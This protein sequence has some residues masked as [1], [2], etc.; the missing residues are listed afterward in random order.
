MFKI[1]DHEMVNGQNVAPADLSSHLDRQPVRFLIVGI[2]LNLVLYLLYLLLTTVGL[3]H[4]MAMT[5]LYFVGLALNF[6][7]HKRWT[8]GHSGAVTYIL[9]RYLA[10]YGVG[11][12]I[13]LAALAFFV[14]YLTYPH[15]LVQAAAM[16][17][18]AL[19]SFLGLR[20]WVFAASRA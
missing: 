7:F 3:G 20:Y 12:F 13:N 18:L 10:V 14:D 8:F 4:K 2:V 16:I 5:S 1:P 19:F 6:Y 11:Y 9:W 17:V 15:A